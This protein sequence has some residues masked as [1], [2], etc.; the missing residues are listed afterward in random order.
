[1][2]EQTKQRRTRLSPEARRDQI[3]EAALTV[4]GQDGFRDGSLQDVA[5]EAGLTQQGLLHYFPTK[6]DL[7]L[8]TL[9]RWEH[10]ASDEFGPGPEGNLIETGR[11]ILRRNLRHVGVMRLRVVISAEAT[12][13]SHPAH[14]RMMARYRATHDFWAAHVASGIERGIYITDLHPSAVADAMIGVLDGLQL[15]YLLRPEMDLIAAYDAACEG[16]LVS[17]T[18]RERDEHGRS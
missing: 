12:S 7:L 4:F 2:A 17:R 10:Q 16:L 5:H 3:L 15:Q 14:A 18:G 8:A 1:M 6:T 11:A 9:D 13:E